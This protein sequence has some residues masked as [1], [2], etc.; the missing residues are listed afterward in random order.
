MKWLKHIWCLGSVNSRLKTLQ[1]LPKMLYWCVC[2]I[3]IIF[4][5]SFLVVWNQCSTGTPPVWNKLDFG[6]SIHQFQT[7][8]YKSHISSAPL[9][10]VYSCSVVKC[11]GE[12][13]AVCVVT[14][15]DTGGQ[16]WHAPQ[17]L[18]RWQWSECYALRM[19]PSSLTL[20][21]HE[22]CKTK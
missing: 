2:S 5:W 19:F 1:W 18:L 9:T 21:T 4:P 17:S 22:T 6:C 20:S 11:F 10:G 16:H 12:W 8:H 15:F 14:M 13:S 7:S 3:L